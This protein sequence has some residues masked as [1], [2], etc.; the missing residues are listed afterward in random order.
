[1]R[2]CHD[3]TMKQN[4]DKALASQPGRRDIGREEALPWPSLPVNQST[5]NVILPPTL[6]ALPSNQTANERK[7]S[8]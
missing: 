7:K 3:V 5:V 2:T 8:E 1:M 4:F 6:P